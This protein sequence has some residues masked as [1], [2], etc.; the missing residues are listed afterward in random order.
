ME[1]KEKKAPTLSSGDPRT[2]VFYQKKPLA[3]YAQKPKDRV[4][5]RCGE[6]N[7]RVLCKRP[8]LRPVWNIPTWIHARC[9][10]ELEREIMGPP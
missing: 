8:S 10:A 1:P 6:K 5:V 7:A 4:C 9:L 3:A 2:V